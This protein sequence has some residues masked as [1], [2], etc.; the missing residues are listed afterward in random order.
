MA[1]SGSCP[2]EPE[3]G[4]VPS[5]LSLEENQVS[6]FVTTYLKRRNTMQIRG[7]ISHRL[8]GAACASQQTVM[9]GEHRSS[10]PPRPGRAVVPGIRV[11]H[12]PPRRDERLFLHIQIIV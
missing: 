1:A 4:S 12:P 2:S 5:L 9:H 10:H 7:S 3:E 6:R 8:R 11:L